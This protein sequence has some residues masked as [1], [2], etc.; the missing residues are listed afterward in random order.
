MTTG[1]NNNSNIENQAIAP[2]ILASIREQKKSKLPETPSKNCFQSIRDIFF[3]Q[4][5]PPTPKEL[6][7]LKLEQLRNPN[8]GQVPKVRPSL[9]ALAKTF[10]LTSNFFTKEQRNYLQQYERVFLP[11][12]LK[13]KIGYELIE[14]MSSSISE[15]LPTIEKIIDGTP[16]KFVDGR[17][18][19][20]PILVHS[21]T[22]YSAIHILQDLSRFFS[23]TPK[24]SLS[25]LGEDTNFFHCDRPHRRA[26]FD[27]I[28]L[29]LSV[30]PARLYSNF[31]LDTMS[32]TYNR[33]SKIEVNGTNDLV[34][35]E[36]H[37]KMKQVLGLF[38]AYVQD[39]QQRV[40]N[41]IGHPSTIAKIPSTTFKE[42]VQLDHYRSAY[43]DTDRLLR[44]GQTVRDLKDLSAL[45]KE[46][47]GIRFSDDTA[48]LRVIGYNIVESQITELVHLAK[49]REFKTPELKQEILNVKRDLERLYVTHDRIPV[50]A[51]TIKTIAATF[52]AIIHC[53]MFYIYRFSNILKRCIYPY[54]FNNFNKSQFQRF[55][56]PTELLRKTSSNEHNELEALSHGWDKDRNMR[57]I[58]VKFLVIKNSTIDK[59]IE[60][61]RGPEAV[62]KF[63]SLAFRAEKLGLPILLVDL[64]EPIE[65]FS[66]F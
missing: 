37:F 64:P 66:F 6:K 51:S 1:I 25:L 31:Q 32:P 21:T 58:N 43:S 62:A 36:T 57:P 56:G 8:R 4:K 28:A 3:G 20:H 44:P 29:G 39:L 22:L 26:G 53:L 61:Y 48:V 40:Y 60:R 27:F 13:E 45:A 50:N 33:N 47:I 18:L 15:G 63:K 5:A 35:V 30:D 38:S 42:P 24:L 2:R 16:F 11:Q 7:E 65:P 34:H 17:N 54:H 9:A 52:L 12:K 10:N 55:L 41:D 14:H 46:I 59:L 23:D 49:H 19:K